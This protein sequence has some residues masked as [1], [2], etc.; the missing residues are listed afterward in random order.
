MIKENEYELT[1][2][3][4]KSMSIA[5]VDHDHVVSFL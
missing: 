3:M 4:L 1:D 5:R 2:A